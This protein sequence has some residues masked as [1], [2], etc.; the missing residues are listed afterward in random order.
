ML[1][2]TNN[3]FCYSS[4]IFKYAKTSRGT[5]RRSST[6]AAATSHCNEIISGWPCIHLENGKK[7]ARFFR[8]ATGKL[9]IKQWI[10]SKLISYWHTYIINII[11]FI[12]P[13]SSPEHANTTPISFINKRFFIW[14]WYCPTDKRWWNPVL[15]TLLHIK[16]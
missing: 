5:W 4:Y 7:P 8:G 13:S 3:A 16:N 10:G 1:L 2:I 6:K 11:V 9:K 12:E 15:R 14:C